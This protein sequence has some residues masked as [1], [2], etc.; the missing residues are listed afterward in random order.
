MDIAVGLDD[1]VD[2]DIVAVVAEF[3]GSHFQ[4]LY[5]SQACVLGALAD[6]EHGV[7]EVVEFLGTGQVVLGDGAGE[8]SL[9]R[10]GDDQERPAVLLLEVHQFHHKDAG[11]HTL[12]GAV[13][14]VGQVVDDGDLAMEF[15][16]CLLD[17]CEDFFFVVLDIQRH[18]VDLCAEQAVRERVKPLGVGIGV[19]HLE[20]L[21]TE[22]AV[23]EED[24]L[25]DGDLFGHLDGIDGFAQVGVGEEAADLAFVP[26]FVVERVGIRPLAG[27]GEGAV[28]GLDGEHSDVVRSCRTLH[29]GADCFDRID[30]HSVDLLSVLIPEQLARLDRFVEFIGIDERFALEFENGNLALLG[31]AVEG[32]GAN[33]QFAARLLTRIVSL[34]TFLGGLNAHFCNRLGDD[35]FQD[36]LD[37]SPNHISV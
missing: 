36:I 37:E 25:G 3:T 16:H 21:V 24:V 23:H 6:G 15:V 28:G 7:K 2:Q 32:C 20:L 12:V 33:L 27:V 34:F 14:Q 31:Q 18:R 4:L 35:G 30:F 26:E 1:F 19:A 22:F 13:A 8:A 11:I 10:M 5:I 29:F 17:V 9:G